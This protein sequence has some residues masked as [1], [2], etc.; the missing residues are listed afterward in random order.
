[1]SEEKALQKAQAELA[2]IFSVGVAS[3][4]LQQQST[5]I[6]ELI[7][8]KNRVDSAKATGRLVAELNPTIIERSSKDIILE[9]GDIIY[10]PEITNTVTIMGDVLNPVTVPYNASHDLNDYIILAGGYTSSADKSKTYAILPNGASVKIGGSFRAFQGNDLMPGS[11]IIVPKQARPL[12]GL[13]LV[14]VITP[15]L[16]TYLLLQLQ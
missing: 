2:E 7:N 13:S 4:I 11:T 9:D 15:I 10:M 14:E 12:S 1:M 16:A 6:I 5:D 8:L 3:G